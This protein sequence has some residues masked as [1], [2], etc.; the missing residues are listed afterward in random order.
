MVEI[1]Q[2]RAYTRASGQYVP[3]RPQH[4][5]S[6]LGPKNSATP[7]P[8]HCLHCVAQRS[9]PFFAKL[10]STERSGT[11][12]RL[13]LTVYLA[14]ADFIRLDARARTAGLARSAWAGN[15]IRSALCDGAN[16]DDLLLDQL[17]H[18]RAASDELIAEH[19]AA[20]DLRQRIADRCANL[21]NPEDERI[22]S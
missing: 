19:P 18:L 8:P 3:Y 1:R 7:T 9:A 4:R 2:Y 10:F 5:H 17:R 14:R 22:S 6:A 16:R 21:I 15:A 13:P 20:A 12:A 11:M